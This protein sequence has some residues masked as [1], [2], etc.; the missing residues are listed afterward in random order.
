[1]LEPSTVRRP[2]WQRK[3]IPRPKSIARS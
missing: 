2:R 3:R 1:V